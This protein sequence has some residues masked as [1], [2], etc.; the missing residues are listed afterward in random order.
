M[1]EPRR[2]TERFPATW[3]SSRYPVAY[4]LMPKCACSTIGQWLHYL[5]HKR[6]YD[7]LVHDAD[8]P[9]LKWGIP[10]CRP[11]IVDRVTSEQY[12]FFAMVRNP[13]RRLVSAFADKI[14]GYQSNG[15]HYRDG[16]LHGLLEQ[17]GYRFGGDSNIFDNFRLFIRF[18]VDTL[19]GQGP[20]AADP[21][22]RPCASMLRISARLN[23]RW[24]P[25]E[26]GHVEHLNRDLGIIAD[27]A[28]VPAAA[29]PSALP[30]DNTTS[31]GQIRIDQLFG[32]EECVLVQEVYAED[33]AW[34]RYDVDL[35]RSQPLGPVVIEDVQRALGETWTN[36]YEVIDN[37]DISS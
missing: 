26:I 22:W 30:R 35:G 33:F 32:E 27:R 8:T 23:P 4:R 18:V 24:V 37:P 17:Y 25:G 28:G 34:F 36:D 11:I 5:D 6:F 15:R 2:T 7:G 16:E 20:I 14:I 9:I 10:D 3:I 13:Y 21:H 29:R 19:Q 12:V 31:L 1:T